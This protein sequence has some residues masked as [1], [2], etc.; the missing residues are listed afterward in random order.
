[1]KQ[2][3]YIIWGIYLHRPSSSFLHLQNP[4]HIIQTNWNYFE[5]EISLCNLRII[6]Y[7]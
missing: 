6:D 7:P 2:I 4:A 1:M 5:V 3:S